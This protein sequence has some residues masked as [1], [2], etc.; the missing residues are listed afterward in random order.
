MLGGGIDSDLAE[1]V[2][3]PIVGA[4]AMAVG[5]ELLADI[6]AERAATGIAVIAAFTAVS[7]AAE[8]LQSLAV[9]ALN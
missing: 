4:F 2:A 3:R 1:T 5:L 6:G 7:L 8:D 9:N